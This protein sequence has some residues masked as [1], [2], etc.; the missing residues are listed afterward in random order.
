MAQNN[1]FIVHS[2]ESGIPVGLSLSYVVAV[3]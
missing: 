1:Y 3:G 2:S